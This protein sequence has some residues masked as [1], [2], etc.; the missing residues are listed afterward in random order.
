MLGDGWV[1]AGGATFALG[2]IPL[3]ILLS[4]GATKNDHAGTF[5][6]RLL[7]ASVATTAVGLALILL[8]LPL[9]SGHNTKVQ[10]DQALPSAPAKSARTRPEF[11]AF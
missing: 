7:V 9:R 6:D 4:S 5:T 8:S 10:V 11:W 3:T 1:L 2:A